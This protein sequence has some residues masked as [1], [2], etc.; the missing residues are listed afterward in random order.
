M[1]LLLNAG[2]IAVAAGLHFSFPERMQWNQLSSSLS[3]TNQFIAYTYSYN[4]DT[5][6]HAPYG[7]YVFLNPRALFEYPFNG[8][9]VFAGYCKK[10]VGIRWLNQSNLEINCQHDQPDEV[11]TLSKNAYGIDISLVSR[12]SSH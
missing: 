5:N 4:S 12:D 10:E 6:W 8:H 7:S 2:A 1:I 3:P 11:H 9:T